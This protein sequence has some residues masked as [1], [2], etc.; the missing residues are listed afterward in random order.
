MDWIHKQID[1]Y[2]RWLRDNTCIRKD[3]GTDWYAI[4]TPF[5]GLFNDHIEIFVKKEGDG[6]IL[7]DDGA[8]LRNLSLIGV[9]F[10][11]SDKRKEMLDSVINPH[12]VK[13]E[14]GELVV[15]CGMQDFPFKKQALV[16][17]IM[18]V[19]DFE[20][21]ASHR[22]SSLFQEDVQVYL[23][24]KDVNYS[25]SIYMRGSSG[26][27]YNFNFFI[28]GKN[29]DLCIKTYDI[30]KQDYVTSLL[31][32]VS[33]VQNARLRVSKKKFR[34]LIIVNDQYREPSQKLVSVLKDNQVDVVLWSAKQEM[35]NMLA[36]N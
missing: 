30:I 19:C 21:I 11:R 6:I 15:R 9:D 16:T 3:V 26:L 20:Y 2:C 28:S 27:D 34:S 33:D 36:M 18:N 5:V 32:C 14:D 8:T 13:L 1:G 22:V 23:D 29:T 31:Y 17:A 10:A 24:S 12:G 35:D 25:S 7:S 4:S